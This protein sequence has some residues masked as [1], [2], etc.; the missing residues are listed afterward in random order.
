MKNY[1]GSVCIPTK[2]LA[3]VF[4]NC[5]DLL[6]QPC[7]IVGYSQAEG[8]ILFHYARANNENRHTMLKFR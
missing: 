4:G 8:E 2:G 7:T 1:T 6:F 3:M 5:N